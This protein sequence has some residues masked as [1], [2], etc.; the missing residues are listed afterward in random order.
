MGAC[1]LTVHLISC[2]RY[3]SCRKAEENTIFKHIPL[4]IIPP[5]ITHTCAGIDISLRA[6]EC[7]NWLIQLIHLTRRKAEVQSG[8]LQFLITTLPLLVPPHHLS[9][10]Q[11]LPVISQSIGTSC[12][13]PWIQLGNNTQHICIYICLSLI[14][15]SLIHIAT[16]YSPPPPPASP[17]GPSSTRFKRSS[18]SSRA[19]K[20]HP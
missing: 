2:V 11:G 18:R 20:F 10:N 19:K 12:F 1:G 15:V 9:A 3:D 8:G 7:L 16:R 13:K 17:L 4:C 6:V 14:V 5:H